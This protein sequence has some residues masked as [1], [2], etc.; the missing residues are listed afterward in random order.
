MI[1]NNS[2]GSVSIQED[3]F[4]RSGQKLTRPV[5]LFSKNSQMDKVELT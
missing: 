5:V 2:T 4:W 1:F 3:L